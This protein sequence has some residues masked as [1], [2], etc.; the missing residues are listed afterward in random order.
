MGSVVPGLCSVTFRR[1]APDEVIGLAAGAGLRAVEWGADVHLPPGDPAAAAALAARCHDAGLACPSYGSYLL[2]GHTTP[3][4]DEAVLDTAEAL[5]ARTV[6]VWAHGDH[7]HVA[8]A[9]HA[10]VV[11]AL[12]RLCDRAH[13]RSLVVGLEFH[14]GTLTETAASTLELL[15]LVDHPALRTYW[16]PAP[17]IG[18]EAGAREAAAVL[19]RLAHLHVFAWAADGTRLPLARQSGLW[20]AVLPATHAAARDRPLDEA[21]CAYLEF[22]EG[23]DPRALERDAATLVDLLAVSA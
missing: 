5:G 23:D 17:G 8:S 2:A 12:T 11:D 22:V 19:G 10:P 9:D 13:G 4:E 14:P 16:Q 7:R 20:A 18:A 15:A 6:R 3:V 21:V 1:L